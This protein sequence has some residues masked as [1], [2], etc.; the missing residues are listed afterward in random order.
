[1]KKGFTL[2]E[3]IT[4]SILS[5][6]GAS[7]QIPILVLFCVYTT[8]PILRLWEILGT[9]FLI[10]Y[11]ILNCISSCLEGTSK[12]VLQKIE[13]SFFALWIEFFG[14]VLI[15]Q[16]LNGNALWIS[17]S[18]L[19]GSIIASIT[20]QAISEK[21]YIP[22]ICGI[23]GMITSLGMLFIWKTAFT[24]AISLLTAL[25]IGLGILSIIFNWIPV[26]GFSIVSKTLFIMETI[27]MFFLIVG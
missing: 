14:L 9:S 5:G 23:G 26:K 12:S 4:H 16:H 27:V 11:F 25:F 6:I 22:W 3:K 15:F 13:R 19:T 20:L 24:T 7:L 17:F 21:F 10:I 18:I 1:M 8:N 2:G